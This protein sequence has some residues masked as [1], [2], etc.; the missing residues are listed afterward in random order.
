MILTTNEAAEQ[1]GVSPAAI[2]KMVERGELEPLAR[3]SKPWRF[4]LLD[5]AEARLR[6]LPAAEHDRLDALARLLDSP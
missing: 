3:N 6:R 5:V 4:R 1:I 2:W